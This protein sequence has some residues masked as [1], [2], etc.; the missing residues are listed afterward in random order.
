MSDIHGSLKYLKK[1]IEAFE[2]E[3]ADY[4]ILLG[5][6]LYH[7]P[8]N[9]LPEEYNP[10]EVS[11]LLNKYKEVIISVR[12]NCD[13]EVDG[14]ILDFPCRAD[15]SIILHCYKRIFV[16]HGHLY[17]ESNLPNLS[18]GD[19]LIYGHTHI[20]IAKKVDDVFI[21]NPGSISLPKE[22]HLSTYGIIEDNE[23]QVKALDG[24][25]YLEI[26]F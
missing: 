7:G 12:G 5:D 26:K 23:F 17:N 3:K 22:N 21:L 8:R 13:A 20:P 1:G 9:D 24:I 25:V 16:T 6:L 11:T 19:I 4:L 14:M 18:K 10:K 15:Y 2:R